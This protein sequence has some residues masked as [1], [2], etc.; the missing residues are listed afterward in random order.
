MTQQRRL[1]LVGAGLIILILAISAAFL[2]FS[3]PPGFSGQQTQTVL[4]TVAPL[5]SAT[6]DICR[7][8]LTGD[9]MPLAQ[10]RLIAAAGECAALTLLDTQVCNEHTAAWWLDLSS[11][12][13]NCA[14][15]CVVNVVT[16]ESEINWRCLGLMME[17]ESPTPTVSQRSSGCGCGN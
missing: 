12:K 14:P 17:E 10:A 8:T 15:A 5:P 2:T 3:R 13:P 7:S 4:P 11:D 9:E 16:G 6:R 1:L